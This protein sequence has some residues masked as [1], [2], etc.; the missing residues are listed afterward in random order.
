MSANKPKG[1]DF[2]AMAARQPQPQTDVKVPAPAVVAPSTKPTK[3]PT[4]QEASLT[5]AAH[6]APLMGDRI[7]SLLAS[8]SGGNHLAMDVQAQD[9]ILSLADDFLDKVVRQ[10][11][12]VCAH[13]GSKTMDVQDVQMVLAKQWNI[14]LPGLGPPKPPV[15]KRKS[16]SAATEGDRPNKLAKPSAPTDASARV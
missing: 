1:K 4:P 12:K 9:Q 8:I 15:L 5:A 7:Q 10:S 6:M 16:V 2:S 11:L 3:E 13:R 14:V